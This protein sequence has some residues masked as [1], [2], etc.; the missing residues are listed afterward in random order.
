MFVMS[1]TNGDN[2]TS[3]KVIMKK[4]NEITNTSGCEIDTTALQV[5]IGIGFS[6]DRVSIGRAGQG[7]TRVDIDITNSIGD[8]MTITDTTSGHLLEY[9]SDDEEECEKE[10]ALA[11]DA[12]IYQMFDN[13][14][15]GWD[16]LIEFLE[17]EEEEDEEEAAY[18]DS[19]H[20]KGDD[21]YNTEVGPC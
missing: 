2:Q 9:G 10:I 3:K 1:S 13:P 7:S 12:R 19:E 14:S 4:Q 15:C 20:N 21:P 18:A 16:V 11:I 8:V 6:I 17:C 5:L